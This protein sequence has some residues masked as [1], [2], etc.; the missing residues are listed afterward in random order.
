MASGIS[1]Q[2]TADREIVV[3]RTIAGPRPLV[4]DSFTT[5][6]HLDRWWSPTGAKVTT[7]SFEF[8]PGGVW[9]FTLPGPSGK[10]F[11]NYIVWKEIVPPERIVWTYGTKKDD[12][13]AAES[14]ITFADRGSTTEVTLRVIFGSKEERDQRVAQY[15]AVEGAQQA[16]ERLAALF[17]D[18][19]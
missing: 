15:H 19:R 2:A 17:P 14:V 8:R 5:I 16:L 9:E 10:P 3:S 13:H 11:P 1:V 12:P 7:R 18:R 4:F 6:E